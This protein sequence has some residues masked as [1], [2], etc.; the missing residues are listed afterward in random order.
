[1]N[2]LFA[3][4]LKKLRKEKGL[5]Q[6][7]LIDICYILSAL[8]MYGFALSDQIERDRQNQREIIRQRLELMCGGSLALRSRSGGG[9]AVTLTIP[10]GAAP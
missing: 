2:S 3:E 1:M 6:V 10:D 8:S 5:S 9:T 7:Q 4:T